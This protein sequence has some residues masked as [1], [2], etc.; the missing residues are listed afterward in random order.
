MN[1]QTTTFVW[2]DADRLVSQQFG[3]GHGDS[4]GYT[5]L[6]MC[7]SKADPTGSY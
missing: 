4:Y 7:L 1:G 2:D 6:G 3:D 5:G